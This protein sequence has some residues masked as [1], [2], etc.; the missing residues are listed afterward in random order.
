MNDKSL[1]S[2]AACSRPARGGQTRSATGIHTG[3]LALE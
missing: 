2:P 3:E 1:D